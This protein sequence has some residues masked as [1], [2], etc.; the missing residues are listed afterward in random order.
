MSDQGGFTSGDPLGGAGA[1]TGG[2]DAFGRPEAPGY[3][4]GP[5]PPGA[6]GGPAATA[7]APMA[8]ALVLAEWWRRA[9]AAVIDGVVIAVIA[10]IIF[11]PLA[12]IGV[13][14]DTDGGFVALVL[15]F[16]VAALVVAAA[17]LVYQPFMLWR[18]NGQ[19]I[20]KMATGI[21][22]V[23][24]D[25]TPMDLLTAILR[26]VVLKSIV[27]GILASITFSIAYLVDWLWPLFDDENR[28]LH[29]F[30]VRTRV[31]RA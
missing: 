3:G 23:K 24:T 27:L 19:T 26:E 31:V 12:A 17:A 11:V 6:F 25:R 22:V 20:G 4:G 15:A 8:G 9:V 30:P 14:V 21:R 1:P 2:T 28:A 7:P 10:G 16:V 29:D 13:T 5:V 18:T